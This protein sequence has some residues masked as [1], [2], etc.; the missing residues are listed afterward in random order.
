MSNYGPTC[1]AE[2]FEFGGSLF[3][4]KTKRQKKKKTKG[5]FF[6]YFSKIIIYLFLNFKHETKS[7]VRVICYS[8]YILKFFLS[9]YDPTCSAELFEFG[10]SLFGENTRLQEKTKGEFFFYFSKLIIYLFL[11][12][13]HE[14]KSTVQVFFFKDNYNML[15]IL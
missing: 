7:T 12:F 3:G 6:F 13:K 15:L 9:N 14:T 1:L 10:G 5:E 4:E 2:L 8:T 11:N